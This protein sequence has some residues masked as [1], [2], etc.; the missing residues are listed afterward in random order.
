MTW[1][2]AVISSTLR[3]RSFVLW[4]NCNW[5]NVIR[6]PAARILIADDFPALRRGL[7][8]I[9][10]TQTGIEVCGEAGDGEE[11]VE[12]ALALKP[13]LVVL[14]I[15]MPKLDGFEAAQKILS[16]SENM[17]ILIFSMNLTPWHVIKAKKI[18]CR[19]YLQKTALTES[20]LRAIEALLRG[21]SFF[22]D[23]GYERLCNRW[24]NEVDLWVRNECC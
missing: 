12:K 7:R 11:A 9:P 14:D 20:L 2:L 3:R 24:A 15:T 17:P 13:D 18:G 10:E 5:A 22:P 21:D 1:R 4:G 23:D 6:M 19:G 8:A 16:A